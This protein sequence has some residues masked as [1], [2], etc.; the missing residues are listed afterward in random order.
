M[1]RTC[2]VC[3][4]P[5]RK[6]IDKALVSGEATTS[7]AG[8]YLTL[9]QRAVQRHKDEH[10]PATLVKTAEQEDVR[11]ALDLVQQ[12]KAINSASL[13]VLREARDKGQGGLA[14]AAVARIQRQIELQAK[15]LGELDE[16]PQVNILL[17]PD[18]LRVRGALLTALAPHPAARAAVAESL[19]SL[20]G[21]A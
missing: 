8:R 16:R 11:H 5:E 21:G 4:H 15:L 9:H 19:A 17:S 13:Q 6:A 14:L 10:L 3:T 2:T 12:L 20:D 1:P 18:W 7:V